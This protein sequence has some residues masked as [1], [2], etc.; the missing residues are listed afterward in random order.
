VHTLSR[1]WIVSAS[2]RSRVNAKGAL[3]P[4]IIRGN[5]TLTLILDVLNKLLLGHLVQVLRR[6]SCIAWSLVLYR[7]T[8]IELSASC[9]PDNF[10]SSIAHFH[11]T[12]L[13]FKA[14]SVSLE[15]LRHFWLSVSLI[16]QIVFH[17]RWRGLIQRWSSFDLEESTINLFWVALNDKMCFFSDLI[18]KTLFERLENISWIVKVLHRYLIDGEIPRHLL[19][20]AQE[21]FLGRVF[22]R[23]QVLVTL[24]NIIEDDEVIGACRVA[25]DHGL[26]LKVSLGVLA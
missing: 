15:R 7:P 9:L 10:V 22:Q 6:W 17:F 20:H 16:R 3:R 18:F 26:S 11:E 21:L 2:H 8:V 4:R 24:L 14:T 23:H 25:F 12:L 13:A 19:S 5:F 1:H